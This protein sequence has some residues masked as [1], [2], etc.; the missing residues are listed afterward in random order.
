MGCY[1][2]S[3]HTWAS[4][5]IQIFFFI[6][7]DCSPTKTPPVVKISCFSISQQKA[8]VET[9]VFISL[10]SINHLMV[11]VHWQY[12]ARCFYYASPGQQQWI[13]HAC[14]IEFMD[15]GSGQSMFEKD[16]LQDI[17]CN[18]FYNKIV[19]SLQYLITWYN[20]YVIK[21]VQ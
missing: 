13:N 2:L 17:C 12:S 21:K 5:P 8:P 14:L 19:L 11:T 16:F 9:Q 15:R 7:S 3:A 20:S 1:R 6:F 10:F 4:S 18:L